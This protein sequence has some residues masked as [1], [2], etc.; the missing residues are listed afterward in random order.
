MLAA[1]LAADASER[2]VVGRAASELGGTRQNSKGRGAGRRRAGRGAERRPDRRSSSGFMAADSGARWLITGQTSGRH[3]YKN[4][5]TITG[6]LDFFSLFELRRTAEGTYAIKEQTGGWL[7]LHA[8]PDGPPQLGIVA[9]LYASPPPPPPP[10]SDKE[11]KAALEDGQERKAEL[12]AQM[13]KEKAAHAVVAAAAA[14]AEAQRFYIDEQ[15]NGA[16]TMRLANGGYVY[17]NAYDP[18][19]GFVALDAKPVD[20]SQGASSR[21]GSVFKRSWW[22]KQSAGLRAFND[23]ALFQFHRVVGASGILDPRHISN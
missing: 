5:D 4:G 11:W 6:N 19:F 13:E 1:V 18:G 14:E 9:P 22:W 20:K 2:L 15:S 17:E 3:L 10:M 12:W 8:Q 16:F 7:G 23:S 21:S